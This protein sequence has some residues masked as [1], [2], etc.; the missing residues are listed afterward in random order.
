[1]WWGLTDKGLRFLTFGSYGAS[2]LTPGN[3]RCVCVCACVRACVRVCVCQSDL[4]VYLHL[5]PP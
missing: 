3:S 5:L 4:Y 1:M 2:V